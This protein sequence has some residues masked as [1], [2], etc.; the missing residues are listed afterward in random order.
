MREAR[1]RQAAWLGVWTQGFEFLEFKTRKSVSY[2][3][4]VPRNENC[5]H[6]KI[7]RHTC[8]GEASEKA[9]N[10]RYVRA[11]FVDHV[12]CSFIVAQHYDLFARPFTAPQ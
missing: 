3:V 8:P 12:N 9:I 5:A 2:A 11:P 7:T 6:D 10:C 4:I 1:A